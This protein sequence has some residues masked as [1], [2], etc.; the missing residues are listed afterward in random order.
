MK[1]FY[2]VLRFTAS[3]LISFAAISLSGYGELMECVHP[4]AV[5]RIFLL[6]VLVI[7]VIV[8]LI[9]EMHL[10]NKNKIKELEARISELE[11]QKQEHE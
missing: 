4:D 8:T 7:A 2:R 1:Y 6:S 9:W 11:E 3:Y 10:G 5:P